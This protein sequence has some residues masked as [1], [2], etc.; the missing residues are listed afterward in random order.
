MAEVVSW[1]DTFKSNLCCAIWF[2]RDELEAATDIAALI[3]AQHAEMVRVLTE[4]RAKFLQTEPVE[5]IVI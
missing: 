3:E 5:R 1:S 4:S 2:R